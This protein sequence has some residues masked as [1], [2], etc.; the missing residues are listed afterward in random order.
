MP[1][2]DMLVA[3]GVIKG[4]DLALNLM[5]AI[6]VTR[7]EATEDMYR[8]TLEMPYAPDGATLVTPCFETSPNGI[9]V[10]SL[11]WTYAA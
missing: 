6:E 8:L 1:Q 10:Q 7:T 3:K 11:A 5:G 9:R 4:I 2:V